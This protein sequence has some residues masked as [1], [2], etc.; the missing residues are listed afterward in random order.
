M[1]L[2]HT[3]DWHL[4]QIL[5][6]YGRA[7]EQREAMAQVVGIAGEEQ[8]DVMVV[9]GDVFDTGNPPV[10]AQELYFETL[11]QLRRQCPRM[12]IVVVA[13]NHDA[14]G[15][16]EAPREVLRFVDV[17]VVGNVK[18]KNG[19]MET[20]GHLVKVSNRE[21]VRVGSVLA[22]SYPTARCLPAMNDEDGERRLPRMVARLYQEMAERTRGEWEPWPLVVTGH[23]HVRGGEESPGAERGILIGGEDAAPVT[24]FPPEA[25]YVA[26]GHLHKAQRMDGERV[27]YSGSLIPLSATEAGYEHGVTVVEIAGRTVVSRRRMLRRGTGFFRIP[28]RGFLPWG[29]VEGALAGLGGGMPFAQV[30]LQR[31]GLPVGYREELDAMAERAGVRLVEV[32]LEETERGKSAGFGERVTELQPG[33]LFRRAFFDKHGKEPEERHRKVFERV[34]EEVEA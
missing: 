15:R 2:L 11:V 12:E 8:A 29:E 31:E 27:Q 33:E 4:G 16:L 13:G 17:H 23:L 26:L 6:G 19:Q 25:A 7:E 21:G 3:A 34:K 20:A 32:K 18:W 28:E 24:V 10:E 1:K 30:K 14:A 5:R 22:V 9:A